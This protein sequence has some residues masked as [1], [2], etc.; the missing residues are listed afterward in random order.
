MKM[1]KLTALLLTLALCAAVSACGSSSQPASADSYRQTAQAHM[2]KGEYDQAIAVLQQGFSATGDPVL[3]QMIEQAAQGKQ[4]AE[5]QPQPEPSEPAGEPDDRTEPTGEPIPT[6]DQRKVNVFLSNF[7]EANL[8][9]Y[10]CKDEWLI[11]FVFTNAAINRPNA[12]QYDE[13]YREYIGKADFDKIMNRYF[14]RTLSPAADGA[15]YGMDFAYENGNYYRPAADGEFCGYAA[16]AHTISRS[17]DGTAKIAFD[18]FSAEDDYWEGT[19]SRLYPMTSD[20]AYADPLLEYYAGGVA[21]VGYGA[22]ESMYLIRYELAELSQSGSAQIPDQSD[23]ELGLEG[24]AML[25]PNEY[26]G[27]WISPDFSYSNGGMSLCVSKTETG[28]EPCFDFRINFIQA[29]PACRIADVIV[30]VNESAL[31]SSDVVKFTE[32]DSWGI[33]ADFE[34]VLD[35]DGIL[36]RVSNSKKPANEYPSWGMVDGEWALHRKDISEAYAETPAQSAEK[37]TFSGVNREL[38]IP[39]TAGCDLYAAGNMLKERYMAEDG[40]ALLDVYTDFAEGDAVPYARVDL[41]SGSIELQLF[42]DEEVNGFSG[43]D[44]DPSRGSEP[45]WFATLSCLNN[46]DLSVKLVRNDGTDQTTEF[47][48]RA[49]EQ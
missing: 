12:V 24:Q 22:D 43:N 25:D 45:G 26:L 16:V 30:S 33:K 35:Y 15:A 13:S 23:E 17:E 27:E 46:G 44:Y 36:C 38:F 6:Q 32:T 37:E 19:M 34:L 11:S 9:E 20:Q 49:E 48:F 10:P 2:E 3:I 29:A 28:V 39:E 41:P 5:Q 47:L 18:I 14:N 1:R 40:S 7:A 8:P 4:E 31:Y 42:Y 21:T